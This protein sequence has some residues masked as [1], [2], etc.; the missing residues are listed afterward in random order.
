ME[1]PPTRPALRPTARANV[2]DWYLGLPHRAICVPGAPS[3]QLAADRTVMDGKCT[4]TPA[5]QGGNCRSPRAFPNFWFRLS[6]LPLSG[7][8]W[9]QITPLGAFSVTPRTRTRLAILLGA[10]APGHTGGFQAPDPTL[11]WMVGKRKSVRYCSTVLPFSFLYCQ[12]HW[13]RQSH[14]RQGMARYYLQNTL[15]ACFRRWQPF[16]CSFQGISAVLLS[17]K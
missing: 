3:I 17:G 5:L 7:Q 13:R 6:A 2:V 16:M 14:W 11:E 9:R 12:S 15:S 10:T 1:A 8:L 4:H